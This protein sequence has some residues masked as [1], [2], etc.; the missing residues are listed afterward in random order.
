MEKL[1]YVPTVN[2]KI[3]P[4]PGSAAETAEQAIAET[5][6]IVRRRINAILGGISSAWTPVRNNLKE[7]DYLRSAQI[8]S[9]GFLLKCDEK[10]NTSIYPIT[11]S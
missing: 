11:E 3:Y 6:L 4:I 7:L 1:L 8:G 5:R 10:G 2:G 9:E